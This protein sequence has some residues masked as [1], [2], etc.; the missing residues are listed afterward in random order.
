MK[1]DVTN[2]LNFNSNREIGFSH[3]RELGFDLNRKLDFDGERELTFDPKRDLGFGKR[4]VLFRGYVCPNCAAIVSPDATSCGECGAEFQEPKTM[5]VMKAPP[6]M[7][8]KFERAQTATSASPGEEP[9]VPK[10]PAIYPPAPAPRAVPRPQTVA[11]L[12]PMTAP[13]PAESAS[14]FCPNCGA[15]SWQGDAFCW[16]CGARF[17]GP[18]KVVA[19]S[20]LG[21]NAPIPSSA[22]KIQL[23]PKKAKKVVK[24]WQDTGK[25][26]EEYSEE[27]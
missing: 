2:L 24:D 17:A 25:T 5:G 10:I 15:R 13:Q 14:R 8:S 11:P 16:N 4:G 27:K 3:V 22:E 23:P 1:G 21:S 7:T 26:W 9:P 6:M 19:T 18:A 20:P 12:P